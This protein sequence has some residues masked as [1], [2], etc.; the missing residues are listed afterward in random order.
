MKILEQII[1]NT[2]NNLALSNYNQNK[3]H[4]ATV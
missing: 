3:Y 4:T 1:A 2:L